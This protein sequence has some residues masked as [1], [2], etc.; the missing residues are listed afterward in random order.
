M[1]EPP[2]WLLDVDGV[3]NVERPDWG[4]V[5]QN[6]RAF[7]EGIQW[8]MRW[9][10]PLLARIRRLHRDGVVEVRWCSTWCARP[11][12][13]QR[14][15]RLRFACAFGAVPNPA[16]AKLAAARA[17]LAGGR[18]LVWTDDDVV[19]DAGAMVDELTVDGRALLIRPDPRCG[20]TP[21]HLDEIEAFAQCRLDGAA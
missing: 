10:P 7:A 13:L 5:P 15:L 20:L 6:G 9:A 18:R 4:V 2:V 8:R 3:V 19:P 12:E 17:V 11:G 14:V 16:V 1:S 21:A